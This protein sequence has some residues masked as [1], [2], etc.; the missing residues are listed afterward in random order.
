VRTAIRGVKLTQEE[1]EYRFDCI[2]LSSVLEIIFSRE[3][4]D[5][6]SSLG[7]ARR[8]GLRFAQITNPDQVL[9]AGGQ[10]A[11]M[12]YSLK[13]VSE[14]EYTKFIHS[15]VMPPEHG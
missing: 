14:A 6:K 8:S 1:T 10:D 3:Y 12:R 5:I 15:F 11:D 2:C 4:P 13:C 9:A 7:R